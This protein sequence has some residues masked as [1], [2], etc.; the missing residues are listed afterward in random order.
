MLKKSENFGEWYNEV[1]EESGLT[2]KRYPVKGMN[3]WPA[4][5]WKTMLAI[6]SV[7]RREFDSRGH[8]EVYF[9]LLIPEDQFEKE[10][11]HIKG[12][13]AQVFWVT[14]AGDNDLDIR[15]LLRPTSET[16]MYPIFSVWI[17]SHADLPL[18]VYQIV[19][20]FRYETKQ[21]RAF[22]RVREI[23]FIEGHTCH[24]TFE[25]AE[26]QIR[27]DLE[28]MKCIADELCLPFRIIRRTEWDKF[29]G[30]FYTYGID[31]MLPDGRA[32]Q[33]A[34]IHQYRTNFSVPYGIYFEEADGSR[35]PVHQTTYGMS[36]RML[37]AV[38]AIHGDDAGLVMPP[39][40]APVQILV[41]PVP[42]KGEAESITAGARK[43]YSK[44]RRLGYRVEI[45]DRD[46]RPGNKYYYWERKG[47]PLRLEVGRR[48][49]EENCVTAV[50]R[51]T[52]E[53]FKISIPVLGRKL[54]SVF[55]DISLSILEK[56]KDKVSKMEFEVDSPENIRDGYNRM[57]WCG[58]E[59]CGR[60]IEE[61]SGASL[62]GTP[63][64]EEAAHGKCVICGRDSDTVAIV[65]RTM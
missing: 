58:E 64:G 54:S 18:R 45:D 53:K 12:F 33:I 22:I 43:V 40:I 48:E 24:A 15:L 44:I 63:V 1:V 26:E 34:S 17:R 10:K 37:G 36:E 9:P 8:Q 55:A 46:I 3:V 20:T 38:V 31:T 42:V 41:V 28:I 49:L 56:A 16:A 21:T 14:R 5:G 27:E 23:Q 50:R 13:D 62:L 30:A 19:N 61:R 6:N 4:Y 2:D 39:S 47:V 57:H 11:E 59:G 25:E 60:K 52:G 7:V 32:L 65:A 51:D 35:E 29:P